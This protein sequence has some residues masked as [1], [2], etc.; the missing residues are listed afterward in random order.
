M[1]EWLAAGPGNPSSLHADGRRAK[2]A[3]DSAREV[4]SAAAGCLFG[5]FVFTS[6]GTESANTAVIGGAIAAPDGRRRVLLGAADHHCVLHTRPR[7]ERLGFTVEEVP[8]DSRAVL[9]L[10]ALEAM[11]GED[12]ALVS[13]LH[14]S[15]ELGVYSPVVQAAEMAK[16]KGALV[17]LDAVQT[18]PA[19]EAA[20]PLFDLVSMSA[21]KLN[22]P[23][24]VGGLVVKAGVKPAP[25]LAGGGQERELRAGTENVAGI[26]GFAAAMQWRASQTS[27]SERR[28]AARD[29]FVEELERISPGAAVWTAGRENMAMPEG[30]PCSILSGHAHCRFPGV[31]AESM[32]IRL[33]LAGVSASS[34]AACSSGSLE[35]SHVLLACGFSEAEAGEGL[36]FTFGWDT[37]QDEA[38]KAAAIVAKAAQEVNQAG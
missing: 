18:F 6:S 7:L 33:D 9:Q 13:L 23:Q 29:A 10:D 22:G 26:V 32:L 11:L 20:S 1:A 3:L 37:P 12:V 28:R 16:A 34:G 25:H 4:L 8:V 21:H 2:D 5:E 24:G 27:L 19:A 17:H 36:R 35:P 15:N 31:S 30:E 38:R 14:A